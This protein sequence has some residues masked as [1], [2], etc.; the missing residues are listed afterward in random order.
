[1]RRG[2]GVQPPP[3]GGGRGAGAA[4]P[5]RARAALAA[6]GDELTRTGYAALLETSPILIRHTARM[7]CAVYGPATEEEEVE[8][9]FDNLPV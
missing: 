4:F 3:G 2:G 7:F 9:G 5:G 8:A 6:A 1:M